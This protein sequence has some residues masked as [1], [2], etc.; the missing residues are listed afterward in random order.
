MTLYDRIKK[1]GE[2]ASAAKEK[3]SH[4]QQ[5]QPSRTFAD[6]FGRKQPSEPVAMYREIH[7]AGLATGALVLCEN[8]REFAL[9]GGRIADGN[10]RTHGPVF[11]RC[12]FDCREYHAGN[13]PWS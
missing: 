13:R 11:A 12:P 10:C 7:A 9:G 4:S 3:L 1:K 5:S 6:D 2:A 8:C